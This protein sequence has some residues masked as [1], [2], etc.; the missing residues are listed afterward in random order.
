MSIKYNHTL[1]TSQITE[2]ED[3]RNKLKKI[4]DKQLEVQEQKT[5][6][7]WN[8][9]ASDIF[10]KKINALEKHMTTTIKNFNTVIEDMKKAQKHLKEV[11][12]KNASM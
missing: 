1:V 10:L 6:D 5:D 12:K 9:D 4:R 11:E 8:G 2:A 7:T 3:I